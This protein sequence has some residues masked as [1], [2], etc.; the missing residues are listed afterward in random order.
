MVLV[1]LSALPPWSLVQKMAERRR[2]AMGHPPVH[3]HVHD[4]VHAA[5]PEGI[6]RACP[7]MSMFMCTCPFHGLSHV[8]VMLMPCA[9]T[10]SSHVKCHVHGRSQAM[11]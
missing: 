8:P 9:R 3:V 10:K 5:D 1:I 11:F 7:A 6:A 2:A 4:Q